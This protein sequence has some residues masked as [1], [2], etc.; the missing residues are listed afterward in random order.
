MSKRRKNIRQHS[1]DADAVRRGPSSRDLIAGVVLVLLV[2]VCYAPA[3]RAGFVWDDDAVTQNVLLR[4]FDGLKQIWTNPS[5]NRREAHYWPMVYTVFWLDYRLWG[6]APFG[7]HL[8]NV[9]LH[10]LNAILLWRLLKQ[11]AVPGAW[12]AAAVFA[13]HPL[14]VESVAWVI[15]LK[16]LL[17]GFFYLLSFLAFVRYSRAPP[18]GLVR[19]RVCYAGSLLLFVLAMLSK[20]ITVTLPV[21]LLLWRWWE[22]G[23]L[24]RRHILPILPFV[25]VAAALAVVDWRVARVAEP[26]DYGLVFFERVLIAGRALWFYATKLVWPAGLVSIY[27]RWDVN[28]HAVAQW[29]FPAGAGAVAVF[30]WAARHRL[31]RGPF[32]AAAYF[33]CTV[34]PTLG[35][36]DYSFMGHA[37]V[38][39]RFIYLA[40]IGPIAL[41]AAG[42]ARWQER[43]GT[44]NTRLMLRGACLCLL[45][46]LGAWTARQATF[47]R[48]VE[49]LFSRNIEVNPMAGAAHCN[50]GLA[51]AGRGELGRAMVHYRRALAI[52]PENVSAH[53]NLGVALQRQG[54]TA[55]AVEHYRRA[56]DLHP[57]DV[58]AHTNLGNVYGERGE[59]ERAVACYTRAIELHP[60]FAPA[61][62]N[63]GNAYRG[64]G[65]LKEAVAAHEEAIRLDPKNADIRY[66]LALAFRA[67]G[68]LPSAIEAYRQAIALRPTHALAHN[69]LAIVHYEVGEYDLAARHISQAAELGYRVDPETSR[70]ILHGR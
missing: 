68:D 60:H 5:A 18:G 29:A 10:A 42:M 32:A 11:I 22:L 16:D 26:V 4:S 53:N 56:I 50:F 55:E 65:M 6:L 30:L 59:F 67:A 20:S 28:L 17:S 51:L 69:N 1:D 24:W 39:D 37:F 33:V 21:A 66:N 9:L 31:G 19:A 14:R 25:V 70:R 54:K 45:I 61:H 7:Y 12:L 23:R 15:E 2:L 58:E 62:N 13:L 43:A 57:A 48:D 52:D 41:A 34:G 64:L 27:P 3:L 38:A 49:S 47:Y 46:G 40:G 35:F 36:I 44:T 63:L 8:Q